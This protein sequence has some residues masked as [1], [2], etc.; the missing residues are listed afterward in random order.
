M[1]IGRNGVSRVARPKISIVSPCWNEERNVQVCYDTVRA[2]F[3]QELPDC[4]LEYI[5]A[6]NCSTDRHPSH[7]A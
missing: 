5:F 3:E 6:D 2:I 1:S 7:P 4:E